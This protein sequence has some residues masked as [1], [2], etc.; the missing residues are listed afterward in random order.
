MAD[1]QKPGD[2]KPATPNYGLPVCTG[3]AMVLTNHRRGRHVFTLHERKDGR[4]VP[5]LDAEGNPLRVVLGDSADRGRP[6]RDQPVA[7]VSRAIYDELVK[8]HGRQIKAL[9]DGPPARRPGR[10]L[11]VVYAGTLSIHAA[12]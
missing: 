4:T 12:A 1:P 9:V 2:V 11:G 5:K 6:G 3:R 7:E 10:P 8:Q